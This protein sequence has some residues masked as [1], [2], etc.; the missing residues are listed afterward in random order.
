MHGEKDTSEM[1]G[2]EMHD[3]VMHECEVFSISNE[4]IK[5]CCSE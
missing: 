4:S 3:F 1:L 5:P 2:S